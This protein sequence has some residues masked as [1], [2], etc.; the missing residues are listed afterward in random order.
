[1]QPHDPGH[2]FAGPFSPTRQQ[3]VRG[4]GEGYRGA[5]VC[6]WK[7]VPWRQVP[8]DGPPSQCPFRRADA[9]WGRRSGLVSRGWHEHT[10]PEPH[11]TSDVIGPCHRGPAALLR[12]GGAAGPQW[13][14]LLLVPKGP[15]FCFN[16]GVDGRRRGSLKPLA[17]KPPR[18]RPPRS[19]ADEKHGSGDILPPP[20]P[21]SECTRATENSKVVG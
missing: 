16:C 5:A 1:M 10:V 14:H 12:D 17:P 9:G 18:P 15:G 3:C 11:T 6:C 2:I 20:P 8:A 4:R 19:R 13:H 7:G 21:P